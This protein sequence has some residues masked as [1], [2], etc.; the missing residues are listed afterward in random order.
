MDKYPAT[1]GEQASTPLALVP[2]EG[3]GGRVAAGICD[4]IYIR[5]MTH[6]QLFIAIGNVHNDNVQ[7][8]TMELTLPGKRKR[9]R[10]KTRGKDCL[11]NDMATVGPTDENTRNRI[12]W[13]SMI[14]MA[15]APHT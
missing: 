3:W 10:S 13:G 1:R 11:R 12:V 8:W 6:F 4:R 14:H 9:G 7:M 15:A 5:R 2:R